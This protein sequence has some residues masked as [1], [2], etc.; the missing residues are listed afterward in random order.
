MGYDICC[1]LYKGTPCIAEMQPPVI[2]HQSYVT[3]LN[4]A[5]YSA[6]TSRESRKT[7]NVI[8]QTEVWTGQ[9]G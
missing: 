6:E 1:K 3:A 2:E 5:E 7:K 8:T 4:G 9:Q